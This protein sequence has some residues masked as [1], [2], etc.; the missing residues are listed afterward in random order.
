MNSLFDQ[1]Q[2]FWKYLDESGLWRKA[3]SLLRVIIKE[4]SRTGGNFQSDYK[5]V[6]LYNKCIRSFS[7]KKIMRLLNNEAFNAIMSDFLLGGKFEDYSW[8]DA[9]IQ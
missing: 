6:T 7:Q 2:A 5:F 8:S 3:V 1:D 9:T 4:D